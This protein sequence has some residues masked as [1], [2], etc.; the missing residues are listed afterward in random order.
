MCFGSKMPDWT[1]PTDCA[2]FLQKVDE[3]GPD[4][5]PVGNRV[6]MDLKVELL[7]AGQPSRPTKQQVRVIHVRRD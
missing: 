7:N 4:G 5:L 6:E 1:P 3:I 2:A